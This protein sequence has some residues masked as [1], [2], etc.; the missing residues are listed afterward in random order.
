M[1]NDNRFPKLFITDLDGTALGGFSPYSRFP[2]VF[3]AFL[4][5]LDERGCKW[6]TNTAWEA[7]PQIDLIKGSTMKSI[8]AYVSGAVSLELCIL[9]GDKL[10]MVQPYSDN[11]QEKLEKVHQSCMNAF[12]KDICSKFDSIFISY[13]KSWFAF[14][15]KEELVEELYTYVEEKYTDRSE[16]T[17]QL[18]RDEKRIIALPAF[19]TKDV[20]VKEI[21]KLMDLTPEDVIVAG[22]MEM[23]LSMMSPDVSKY[24]ICPNNACQA[25]KKHVLEMG[26]VVGSLDYGP[27]IVEAF[28][29]LAK[30]NGWDWE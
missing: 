17:I 18:V 5:K 9:K 25:V 20:V 16:L 2:D 19:L 28:N 24:Y 15:P 4:D 3:S 27:G 26:G 10:E 23:D 12:I 30:I 22:D 7:H 14:T 6:A 8:P 13:N 11:M 29:R 21:L 1:K